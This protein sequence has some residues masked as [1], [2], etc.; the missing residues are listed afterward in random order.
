[1]FKTTLIAIAIL[2]ACAGC[3]P[4][5]VDE[6][7]AQFAAIA[8]PEAEFEQVYTEAYSLMHSA[9]AE[10]HAFFESLTEYECVEAKYVE[11]GKPCLALIW[12]NPVDG[13]YAEV[14]ELAETGHT[15]NLA[16]VD[17]EAAIRRIAANNPDLAAACVRM[18]DARSEVMRLNDARQTMADDYQAAYSALIDA[19][20]T[21]GKSAD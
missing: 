11:P 14:C 2:T 5:P 9:Q 18:R 13:L 15:H 12:R 4:N 6:A 21:D 19:L 8:T 1:M 7:M 10:V 3:A 17:N 16:G 20:E